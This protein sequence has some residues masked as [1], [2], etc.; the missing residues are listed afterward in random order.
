LNEVEEG[1]PSAD[2]FFSY[3]DNET[4]VGF[5]QVSLRFGSFFLYML[6][7]VSQSG[8]MRF[9]YLAK[10]RLGELTIQFWE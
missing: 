10:V 6:P 9:Y 4:K 1:H 7:I 3:A 2:I 8:L 5:N